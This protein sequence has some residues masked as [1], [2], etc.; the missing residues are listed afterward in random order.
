MVARPEDYSTFLAER[1]RS[2]QSWG[3]PTQLEDIW[4]FEGLG[5]DMTAFTMPDGVHGEVAYGTTTNFLKLH[6]GRM[7]CSWTRPT[8]S[9]GSFSHCSDHD[10]GPS[11]RG[12]QVLDREPHSIPGGQ[13]A[14]TLGRSRYPHVGGRLSYRMSRTLARS[15]DV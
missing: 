9:T 3:N 11:R 12:E 4:N 13:P 15:P 7:T 10:D 6:G 5:F 2:I 14:P 1:E 8:C